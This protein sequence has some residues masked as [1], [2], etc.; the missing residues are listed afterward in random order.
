MFIN[1]KHNNDNYLSSLVYKNNNNTRTLESTSFGGGRINKTGNNSYDINYF[2]TDH[3]GSTRVIV[4]SNGVI[5]EQKDFYPFGKEHE[6]GN[7]MTSTNRWGFNGKEKQTIKD[8]GYWDYSAR[9]LDS[10]LGRWFVPDPLMEKYYSIS[11]Y[12][13]CL[14]NP[15]RAVDFDGRLVIFINGMHS[16]NGGTPDYWGKFGE[17]IMQHLNDN[18]PPIYRDGSAGGVWKLF[19]F[20]DSNI[21]ASA[22]ILSGA[23]Q[24]L[25]DAPDIISQITDENGNITETIKIITHSM[26]AAY[27]KG[28]VTALVAYLKAHNIPLEAIAFEADFA[29]FQPTKQKAVKGVKTYQFTNY[30]DNVA[31]HNPLSPYGYIE[32]AKVNTDF[33]ENKGHSLADY[34]DEINN[35]PSGKYKFENGKIV[36]Y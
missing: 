31:G 24:G 27:A 28:Y 22:R 14:N 29:P 26:G 34:W 25:K 6:N 19:T 35:L 36:P 13:Y 33:D 17:R 18:S 23:Q 1:E 10:E 21:S 12:A 4:G 8:L 2:I 16:G 32:G 7:L 11:P 15:I 30:H 20:F 5:K 9:M 3:L